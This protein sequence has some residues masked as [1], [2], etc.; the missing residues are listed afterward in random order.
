MELNSKLYLMTKEEAYRKI[1][2]TPAELTFE[3]V[4]VKNLLKD[5]INYYGLNAIR[6]NLNKSETI[7]LKLIITDKE[8]WND[9]SVRFRP[10][11][12]NIKHIMEEKKMGVYKAWLETVERNL[13][14]KWMSDETRTAEEVHNLAIAGCCL[15]INALEEEWSNGTISKEHDEWLEKVT[16]DDDYWA[17]WEVWK[18]NI[19]DS[20]NVGMSK[21][22]YFV[23]KGAIEK[24]AG[25][26]AQ[27]EVETTAIT[28]TNNKGTT[29]TFSSSSTT[30]TTKSWYSFNCNAAPIGFDYHGRKNETI[31]P[32]FISICKMTQ[33]TLKKY[34]VR[35]LKKYYNKED[36]YPRDGFVFVK[37]E[38]PVMVTA[39][40]DTVHKETIKNY[41]EWIEEQEDKAKGTTYNVHVLSSPQG[42]GGDDRCGIWMILQILECGYRPFIIFNEDEEIGC[43]GANK[44]CK[45]V[46]VDLHNMC[47]EVKFIIE[48]DRKGKHDLVFYD[49]ANDDFTN[50]CEETTGWKEAYGTCSDI[51]YIAPKLGCA[52]VN[53]SCGYYDEHKLWHTVKIEE[54]F[55]TLS[56][57]I[58]MIEASETVERF[59]YVEAYSGYNYTWGNRYNDYDYDNYS[60]KDSDKY[61]TCVVDFEFWVYDAKMDDWTTEFATTRGWRHSECYEKFFKRHPN[62]CY[63]D[64]T[65]HTERYD[66][67]HSYNYNNNRA[68]VRNSYY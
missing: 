25:R 66:Y 54:M 16:S 27:A 26:K 4:E 62:T 29:Q 32:D 60:D 40:M 7:Y 2:G 23:A 51:S 49:C 31:L 10:A 33:K 67:S 19:K 28:T 43:V 64:I 6:N 65:K 17:D 1:R 20:K 18:K 30:N 63:A 47:K 46:N 58:K 37:G 42:I 12:E 53:L 68:F 21:E 22:E 34:L 55:N 45:E 39:H 9:I 3:D 48:L 56:T 35:E 15:W 57:A 36:I 52:A 13:T 44:F 8:F 59:E 11:M 14:R 50:W 5:A 61:G 38:I 24:V 41:Y